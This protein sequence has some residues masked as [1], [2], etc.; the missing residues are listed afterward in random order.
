MISILIAGLA[1]SA[2]EMSEPGDPASVQVAPGEQASTLTN[3]PV[4][5]T[6][7]PVIVTNTVLTTTNIQASGPDTP[8]LTAEDFRTSWQIPPPDDDRYDWIQL[9]S[10]EWLKGDIKSLQKDRLWFDSDE[11]DELEFDWK[12]VHKL[13]SPTVNTVLIDDGRNRE[14]VVGSLWITRDKVIVDFEETVSYPREHLFGIVP[15][16]PNEWSYWSG[17]VSLGVT[18]R[19]GNTDQLEYN[20]R[21]SLAR[22][23]TLTRLTLEYLGNFS[24]TQDTETANNHRA[25]AGFDVFLSRYL[26]VRVPFA[27][28][29]RDPFQNIDHRAT[30]GVGVGYDFFNRFNSPVVEWNVSLGP[31]YQQTWYESVEPGRPESQGSSAVVIGTLFN[32]DISRRI[33]F[34]LDYSGQFSIQKDVS[35]THHTELIWELELTKRLDLDVSF[36]WDYTAN[37]Q[38]DAAGVTPERS[39]YRMVLAL[40][41]DF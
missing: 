6:N 2:A 16:E 29:F 1:S 26:F 19:G 9:K 4:M 33:E 25:T 36:I 13:I 37:P 41:L 39:D 38:T 28:Y 21:V 22:R 14:T 17:K 24:R 3:M 27:E 40:G 18:V 23:T 30:V 32:W 15:G 10:G 20:S 8:A 5:A 34:T 35:S 11:L 7:V 31:A 12:D